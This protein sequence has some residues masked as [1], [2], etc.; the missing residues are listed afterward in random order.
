MI[1]HPNSWPAEGWPR[2]KNSDS[3]GST[4]LPEFLQRAMK[5]DGSTPGVIPGERRQA[6]TRKCP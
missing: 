1:D 2:L 5:T 6:F 3:G 4:L